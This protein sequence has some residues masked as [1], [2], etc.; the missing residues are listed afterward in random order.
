MWADYQ[1]DQAP[2]P[3]TG[4]YIRPDNPN[5][6]ADL[7]NL[8]ASRPDPDAPFSFSKRMEEAGP[9]IASNNYEVVQVLAGMTGSIPFA[10]AKDWNWD[11]YG[12]RGNV[13]NTEI[14]QGNVS[15][16]AFETPSTTWTS[17]S[18]IPSRMLS[19]DCACVPALPT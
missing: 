9:R 14:Q 11:V 8:L 16:T 2:T 17:P 15:R 7:A 13:E 5:I 18:G 10:F 4:V 3:M 6:P 1:A 12:S 19:R